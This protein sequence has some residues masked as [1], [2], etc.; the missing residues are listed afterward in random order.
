MPFTSLLGKNY[1]S[2]T[3]DTDAQENEIF[4]NPAPSRAGYCKVSN[5]L[6]FQALPGIS[7][8]IVFST[9]L[10]ETNLRRDFQVLPMFET[11]I[12]DSALCDLLIWEQ[13][14]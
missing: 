1:I 2:H 4:V 3:W 10:S 6:P 11:I 7:K 8:Q 14:N 5:Y 12:C 9:Q 13:H